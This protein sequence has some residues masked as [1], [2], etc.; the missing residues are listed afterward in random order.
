M[1]LEECSAIDIIEVVRN[2][3]N[4]GEKIRLSN[5]TLLNDY[6]LNTAREYIQLEERAKQAHERGDMTAASM[7]N[8]KMQCR[9]AGIESKIK[10]D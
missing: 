3:D 10:N 9:L 6:L 8:Y 5:T 7:A 2:A 1:R 4:A